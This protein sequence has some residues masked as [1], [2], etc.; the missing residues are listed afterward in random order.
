MSLPDLTSLGYAV[1]LGDAD[2]AGDPRW[3]CLNS[4]VVADPAPKVRMNAR[5]QGTVGVYGRKS[6][7]NP[8]TF[9]LEVAVGSA[10]SDGSPAADSMEGL[11]AN[12]AELASLTINAAEDDFGC[13]P[14]ACTLPSGEVLSGPVQVD[15]FVAAPGLEY[16]VVVMQV[17][18]PAGALEPG[19]TPS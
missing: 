6:G 18:I 13:I 7:R 3:A 11:E 12:I 4:H 8:R 16:R 5:A 9:D 2:L 14:M 10:E 19:D 17:T 15:D 1:T